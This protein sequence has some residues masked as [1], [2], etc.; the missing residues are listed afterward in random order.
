MRDKRFVALH[1]GGNLSVEHHRLL[2]HWAICCAEHVLKLCDNSYIGR[3]RHVLS[4]AKEWEKGM[5]TTGMARKASLEAISIANESTDTVSVAVARSVGHAVATAHMADHSFFALEYALKAF[6]LAGL[7]VENERNRMND[8]LPN[9][10]SELV[11]TAQQN[12]F[13][14]S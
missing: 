4:V 10:I 3:L 13:H 11:L 2:I 12:K 7:S 6:K 1:R 5:T 8:F 14:C 9:E